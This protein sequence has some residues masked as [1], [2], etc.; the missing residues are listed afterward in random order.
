MLLTDTLCRCDRRNVRMNHKGRVTKIIGLILTIAMLAVSLY[1][2]KRLSDT[3]LLPA[4]YIR[5]AIAGV[6]VV[7]IFLVFM[8]LIKL[9]N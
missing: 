8:L 3:G 9:A 2:V 4:M 5:V 7:F 6:F 1:A